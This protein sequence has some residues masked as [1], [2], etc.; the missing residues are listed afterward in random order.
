MDHWQFL[1]AQDYSPRFM[2]NKKTPKGVFL[3]SVDKLHLT[4]K[5]CAIIYMYL[6]EGYILKI[7]Q[8]YMTPSK[9]NV[10]YESKNFFITREGSFMFRLVF[11]ERNISYHDSF[12]SAIHKAE[13]LEKQY[14]TKTKKK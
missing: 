8:F 7:T 1:Q 12:S 10:V 5:N 9:R 6:L 13:K 3:F 4:F 2:E 11:K 14:L